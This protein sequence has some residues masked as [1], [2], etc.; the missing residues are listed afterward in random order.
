VA[1]V[2]PRFVDCHSHV[3]PSGDDGAHGVTDG[4]ALCR[5]AAWHGTALLYATPHVW[6]ELPLTESRA[7]RVREAFAQMRDSV[8]LELRLGWELTPTS[9]LLDDDPRRY[10]FEDSDRVLVE[11][12]FVGPAREFVSLVELIESA[13][14]Q[15][16]VAHPER[17]E[18]VLERPTFADELAERG[19]LLQVNSTSLLGRHGDDSAALGWDLLERS[20]AT[21]VA[22]DGHRPTRPPHLDTAYALAVRR[23]GEEQ[24]LPMFDGTNLGIRPSRPASLATSTKASLAMPTIKEARA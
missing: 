18:A 8:S 23:F 24:A 10:V 15:P 14:L 3:V 4:I 22:S 5:E 6:P 13:G 1:G 2:E 12:P 20:V 21:I 17:T 7:A 19:C 16:V 11:I 9:A